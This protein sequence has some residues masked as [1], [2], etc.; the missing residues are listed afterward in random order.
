MSDP[1]KP[2]QADRI[3]SELLETKILPRL[4]EKSDAGRSFKIDDL[5]QYKF[6]HVH[7]CNFVDIMIKNDQKGPTGE[8]YLTDAF[9]RMLQAQ[10]V[11]KTAS[12]SQWLD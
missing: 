4:T 10:L 3:I 6:E 8:F 7:I 12:V 2:V 5:Q 11:F 1:I 9:H